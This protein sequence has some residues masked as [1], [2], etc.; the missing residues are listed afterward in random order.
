[1]IEGHLEEYRALRP[2]SRSTSSRSRRRS[3]A[4]ASSCRRRCRASSSRRAATRCSR[5][6]RVAARP[7]AV[8]AAGARRRRRGGVGGHGRRAGGAQPA[9]DPR[10]ARRGRD[11]RRRRRA[12]PRRHHPHRRPRRRSRR[13]SARA[14]AAARGC[15]SA[16]C[17]WRPASPFAL[18]AGGFDR[19]TFFCGQSGSGKTYSLGVVLEQLL[20]ETSLRIV[21]LDPNSDMVRLREVRDG[22][23]E[24]TAERWRALADG[25]DIRS[26]RRRPPVPAA[27]RAQPRR[28][29]GGA[30]AR[31]GRRPRGARRAR[32]LVDD[33]RPESL[34]DLLVAPR[35]Q[36]RELASASATS[37]S[38]AGACGRATTATRR[39]P[40]SATRAASCSTSA[41][42]TPARSRRSSP[43]AVLGRCGSAA[44]S[45]KPVLIVIDEAHNVC[46]SDPPDA[47]T[48]LATELR[49]PDRR[50]GAQVR[51]LPAGL[52]AAARRRCRRTS[53]PSATTSC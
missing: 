34:E 6:P 25:I 51:P 18:D 40:R 21:I 4:A 17:G 46:P 31:P 14:P 41:R 39:S 47:L 44:P 30:A 20:L 26:G 16:S 42:S 23:D 7:G 1:M 22:V 36:A 28:A 35:P 29:G 32:R 33:T 13:G 5:T 8:A 12:V 3:T 15:R 2:S 27:A 9:R 50:R 53:S 52:H 11:P 48:A 43:S 45:G 24:A 10:G 38:T 19:H 37:A 49:R